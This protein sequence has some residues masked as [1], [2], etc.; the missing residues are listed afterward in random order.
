MTR[1]AI[2]ILSLLF[3]L[4]V[5]AQAPEAAPVSEPAPASEPAPPP[6]RV[7]I[8]PFAPFV[9]PG[10]PPKGYSIDLWH[11]VAASL[12]Q[13]YELV[14]CKGAAD[15]LDRLAK[16][17]L[18]V[19]IGGLTV[20]PQRERQIDFTHPSFRSGL[21]ILLAGL[22][23]PPTLWTRL[24]Y[25]L[26]RTKST[27][28][29][30]FFLL[31]V[32]AGHL[33]WYVERGRDTFNDDY[34]HGVFEGIYWA[35]VTASTVGYGDKAPIKPMGRLLAMLVIVISLPLFAYFTAELA[36]AFTVIDIQSN[37]TRPDDLS[38]RRV[39]VVR[40]TVG[41][42][43]AAQFGFEL[44][45]WDSADDAYAALESGRVDAVIYDAPSLAYYVQTAGRDK[46]HLAGPEFQISNLA[47]ATQSGSPLR[48]RINRALLE[49]AEDGT[50]GDLRIKWFGRR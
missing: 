6:L 44:R 22:D 15:K 2:L 30:A 32:I 42:T 38:G 31:V 37:V 43:Y 48:E 23:E 13:P 12:G 4:P 5:Q 19:A 39:G 20:T 3:A 24:V 33:I 18:D 50:Q 40:G 1:G 17:D 29:L 16:G 27:V 45:Q 41:A 7:G 11:S 28:V 26:G 36:S 9:M 46:S 47:M 49:L 35:V 21:A 8:S 14:M 34:R 25:A 10:P